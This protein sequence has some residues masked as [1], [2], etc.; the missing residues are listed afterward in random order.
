V[1]WA[2]AGK[3]CNAR[4]GT[5]SF[6]EMHDLPLSAR[7]A[8]EIPIREFKAIFFWPMRLKPLKNCALR[9]SRETGDENSS[10]WLGKY[11]EWLCKNGQWKASGRYGEHAFRRSPPS[12]A[13]SYAEFV[14]FHPFVQHYLFLNESIRLLHREDIWSVRLQLQSGGP[15]RTFPVER[16]QM[17]L[18]PSDVAILAVQINTPLES[19]SPFTLA[20][21]QDSLDYARRLYP[22][23]WVGDKPEK[24]PHLMQWVNANGELVGEA[25]DFGDQDAHIPQQP[26]EEI[27]VGAHWRSLVAPLAFSDTDL[28]YEQLEDDRLPTMAYLSVDEPAEIGEPDFVRL[29]F[30][31]DRGQPDRYPYSRDFLANFSNYCYDRFWNPLQPEGF[32]TRYLCAG[33]SFL[34]VGSVRDSVFRDLVSKHFEQPYFVLAL[35]AH[36]QKASLL[37]FWNRLAALVHRFEEQKPSRESR[38]E[39]FRKQKW[40]LADLSDYCCRFSHGEASNQLQGQELFALWTRHLGIRELQAQV[41]EHSRFTR[42]VQF[43]QWQE[44]MAENSLALSASQTQ[45]AKLAAGV[46]PATI[47]LAALSLWLAIPNVA[48]G[49]KWL[50]S[51]RAESVASFNQISMLVVPLALFAAALSWLGALSIRKWMT[52]SR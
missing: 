40:L 21:A 44:D 41:M 36:L 33:Y 39:F 12:A 14:Y 5:I 4:Y 26:E 52:R 35:I 7:D 27:A 28:R 46:L 25:S 23:F 1:K 38:Q 22:P 45:L 13:D 15:V 29:A 17:F 6:T 9:N 11:A 16:I 2:L 43:N 37:V 3:E 34:A 48:E 32:S 42:E 24:V 31:D 49:L 19:E 8:A 10:Q 47:V 30:L 18:F 51:D 20:E 50:V